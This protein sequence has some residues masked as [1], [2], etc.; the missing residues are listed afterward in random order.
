MYR[1]MLTSRIF[2]NIDETIYYAKKNN[3]YGIEWYLNQLRL[4]IN[5]EKADQFFKKLDHYPEMYFTFHFP[6]TD[7]EIGHCN[8][9]YANISLQYLKIYID[10]LSPWLK[11]DKRKTIFTLHVGANSIPM[12]YLSWRRTK[13]S[14][15]VLGD[16]I[17]NANGLLCLENLKM[18]WTAQPEKLIELAEYAGINITFDSGHAAS[19]PLVR[20]NIFSLVDYLNKIKSLVRYVHFYDYE[21][22]KEGYHVPPGKWENISSI[23]K[24]ILTLKDIKGITIELTKVNEL[25]WTYQLI[26]NHFIK[27]KN[28]KNNQKNTHA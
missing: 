21:T 28:G 4:P 7:V 24:K 11:A 14:L 25:E 2:N 10:F 18:G 26:N 20:N 16:Y 13:E 15:K 5:P 23:W 17:F 19:S 9:E 22:L 12:K 8:K 27:A 3:Y 6:T 1:I